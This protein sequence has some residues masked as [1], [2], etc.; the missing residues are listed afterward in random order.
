MCIFLIIES[1]VSDRNMIRKSW[2]KY[3]RV[4]I[5]ILQGYPKSFPRGFEWNLI[6]FHAYIMFYV[7]SSFH[8]YD[9]Y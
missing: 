8:K 1:V 7:I 9:A 2:R 6:A 4:A 3:D 5:H